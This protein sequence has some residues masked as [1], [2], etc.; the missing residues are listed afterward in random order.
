M[1]PFP[2]TTLQSDHGAE[3]SKWFTKR[4]VERGMAH[5]HSRVRQPNDNA[6]LERWNRTLQEECLSRVPRSIRSYQ[7]EIPDYLRYYNTERPH[8]ALEMKTPR[9]KVAELFQAIDR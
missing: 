2:F 8:M 9:E 6:H 1:A 7:K 4:I 3:F 5:R